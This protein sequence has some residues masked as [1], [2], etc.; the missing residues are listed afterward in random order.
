MKDY[1][2]ELPGPARRQA[3]RRQVA[4]RMVRPLAAGRT[5]ENRFWSSSVLATSTRARVCLA[6]WGVNR[7]GAEFEQPHDRWRGPNGTPPA[8]A[9]PLLYAQTPRISERIAC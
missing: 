9:R 8:L 1:S 6:S 4:Q 3:R 7:I 2:R 5:R